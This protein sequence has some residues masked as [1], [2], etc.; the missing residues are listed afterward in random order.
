MIAAPLRRK[1]ERTE[2][3]DT[4]RVSAELIQLDPENPR[5]TEEESRQDQEGLLETLLRRFKLDD[6]ARSILASGFLE[7]DPMVGYWDGETVTVLEGNRRVAAAKLLLDPGLAPRN[8]Q[9]KW[10]E[11]ARGLKPRH[12]RQLEDLPLEIY[13]DRDAFNVL[14][15]I[16]FRHVSGVIQ[17]P[18]L[19]KAAFI[20]RLARQ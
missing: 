7:Y 14:A 3:G 11:L 8:R 6:L 10:R 13:S 15:Y 18:A 1:L 9:A 5:L 16:G 20:A 4:V 12:R 17:W 2:D 19:E